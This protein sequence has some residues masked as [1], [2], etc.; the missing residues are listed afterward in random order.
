MCV[1]V[2][3]LLGLLPLEVLDQKLKSTP[4]FSYLHNKEMGETERVNETVK[5]RDAPRERNLNHQHMSP[6][7]HLQ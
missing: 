2:Y 5:K 4:D 6:N 7:L 3:K 1:C